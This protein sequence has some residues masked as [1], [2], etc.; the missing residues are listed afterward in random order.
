MTIIVKKI[1]SDLDMFDGNKQYPQKISAGIFILAIG[2][3]N[4]LHISYPLYPHFAPWKS[5]VR[6][7]SIGAQAHHWHGLFEQLQ[8][9]LEAPISTAVLVDHLTE[10]KPVATRRDAENEEPGRIVHGKPTKDLPKTMVN[11]GSKSYIEVVLWD[12]TVDL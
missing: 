10:K 7:F 6:E 9:D 3:S 1:T 12:D 8:G 11:G 4:Q 2:Y 5:S